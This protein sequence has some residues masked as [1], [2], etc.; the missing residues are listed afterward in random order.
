M[1]VNNGA[2]ESRSSVPVAADEPDDDSV[3]GDGLTGRIAQ[4]WQHI[5]QLRAERRTPAP[6][7]RVTSGPSNFSRAHVPWGVDLAAAWAWR[8]LVI[9]AAGYVIARV[10]GFLMVVVLPVV[11]A[12]LIAALVEPVVSWLHRRGLP[13]GVAAFLIVLLGIAAVATLLSLAGNQVANGANDLA[14]SV[15]EGLDQI[16]E[17]LR[18]GPLHASESQINDYLDQIQAAISDFARNGDVLSHVTELGAALGHVLAGFFIVL[19]S[20]YFFLADGE[21]I[22]AWV[23]RLSPRASRVL[24]DGSGRVAWVSLTQFVGPP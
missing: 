12:L 5:A 10:L 2:D 13:R 19:F 8:F 16:K 3:S 9:V 14:D 20:T 23:V 22:W 4:Q 15:V 17:W 18:D 7:P 24:V 6:P 11:V 1:P 21:R